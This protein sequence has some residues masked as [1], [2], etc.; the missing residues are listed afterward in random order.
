MTF[1]TPIQTTVP[2]PLRPL[3]VSVVIPTLNE[4]RNLPYVFARLP[5]NITEVVLVDG[6]STDRTVEVARE[7]WPDLVVVHQTRTGKGNAL[8]CGFNACTSDI[9][10]M[11]DADGSTD[12]AEIP[13]FVA[14]LV[15]GADFAKGTRFAS[16]GGSDDITALRRLGNAGLNG[17]TNLMFRTR[18]TDLCYGYNA[19]WR[20]LVPDLDLP[21]TEAPSPVDGSRI[22]GDGFE[23]ETLINIRV[24]GHGYRVHEVPSHESL[25]HFGESKLHAVRDGWRVLR[26]MFSE[27]RRSRGTRR[28]AP[29]TAIASTATV[30]ATRWL[31]QDSATPAV[32]PSLAL[33]GEAH[34][35]PVNTRR[36]RHDDWVSRDEDNGHEDNGNEYDGDD[37]DDDRAVATVTYLGAGRIPAPRAA[38]S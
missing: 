27:Y 32:R 36:P 20:H 21:D 25:R 17:L 19:F 15:G 26:T 18:Y 38:R 8:A 6:G 9:V 34:G 14:A 29:S 16:G 24:S 37:R 3:S 12:P 5:R 1:S 33:A 35:Y 30:G 22:W 7:L 11:I 10:V 28:P 4:E 13:R 23:I 2:T 31:D